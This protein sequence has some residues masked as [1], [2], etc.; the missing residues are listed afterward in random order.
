[1]RASWWIYQ[2]C[3][4]R[5]K[6]VFQI[7]REGVGG[8]AGQ[9]KRNSIPVHLHEKY[10][11]QFYWRRLWTWGGRSP[12]RSCFRLSYGIPDW[13]RTSLLTGDAFLT[14]W[15]QHFNFSL[16]IFWILKNIYLH[17]LLFFSWRIIALQYRFGFCHTSTWISRRY[18]CVSSLLNLP[19]NSHLF[20][21]L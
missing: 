14:L 11:P 18:T 16:R 8:G 3:I 20:P 12:A 13:D 1:M 19:P 21:P 9:K 17:V 15:A 2:D 6:A 10:I 5:E 7:K 4:L